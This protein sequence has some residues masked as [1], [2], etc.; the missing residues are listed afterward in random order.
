MN[1]FA[2]A[3]ALHSNKVFYAQFWTHR[4]KYR[5]IYDIQIKKMLFLCV[6]RIASLSRK[7]R[8]VLDIGFGSGQILFTFDKTCEVYG[9]D[10]SQR[11]VDEAQQYSLTKGY[12]KSRFLQ[13]DLD[14]GAL[15]FENRMF[16]IVVCSH[17]LEHVLDDRKLLKEIYDVLGDDGT[18]VILIPINERPG[19]DLNHVRTYTTRE[20]LML[21]EELNFE[22]RLVRENEYIGHWTSGFFLKNY[23]K[24]IPLLG[25]LISGLIN[26]PLAILPM[27][28]HRVFDWIFQG[29]GYKPRQMAC[30]VSKQCA[31]Q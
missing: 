15:P 9:I 5:F 31:R 30:C 12:R 20:F 23:H 2:A 25:F 24:R 4:W 1:D 10:F 19:D 29:L 3:K 26:V 27:R 16:D 22:V 13:H 28:V 14:A 18:A 6:L 17:V 8:K 11:A 7:S 21:L